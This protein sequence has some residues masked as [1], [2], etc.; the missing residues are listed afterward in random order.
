MDVPAQGVTPPHAQQMSDPGVRAGPELAV[1]VEDL[2]YLAPA[3]EL[4]FVFGEKRPGVGVAT[5]R[6]EVVHR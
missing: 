6:D 5:S 1:P 4:R 2:L 3:D